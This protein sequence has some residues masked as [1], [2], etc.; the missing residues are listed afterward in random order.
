MFFFHSHPSLARPSSRRW[1][2]AFLE[3]PGHSLLLESVATR[4]PWSTAAGRDSHNSF[5][6]SSCSMYV[7]R[8]GT[9]PGRPRWGIDELDDTDEAIA[10]RVRITSTGTRVLSLEKRLGSGRSIHFH[11][12]PHTSSSLSTNPTT[13][14]VPPLQV[15]SAQVPTEI[16]LPYSPPLSC[17]P[18][19]CPRSS[20]PLHQ[21]R[22]ARLSAPLPLAGRR[23]SSTSATSTPSCPSWA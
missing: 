5:L 10:R 18:T 1:S 20:P 3:G 16:D 6:S 14:N 23:H 9:I 8:S 13:N 15:L 12:P 22:N 7:L 17:P 11:A 21:S 4:A 2:L 19:I